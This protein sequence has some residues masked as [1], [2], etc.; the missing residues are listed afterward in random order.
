MQERLSSSKTAELVEMRVVRISLGSTICH[1]PKV[2]R[3]LNT[4]G[5]ALHAL[6]RAPAMSGGP[7][8]TTP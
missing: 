4:K 5:D 6:N 8:N 3:G 1:S 7:R 2:A